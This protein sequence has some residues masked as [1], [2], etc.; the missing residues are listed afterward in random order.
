MLATKTDAASAVSSNSESP[1]KSQ[2][3]IDAGPGLRNVIAQSAEVREASRSQRLQRMLQALLDTTQANP[4]ATVAAF[5]QL[6]GSVLDA[7]MIATEAHMG[8]LQLIDANSQ[9][10]RIRV[11]RGFSPAFLQFFN[12][13]HS[14]AFACGTAFAQGGPVVVED[15]STSPLFE[16]DALRQMTAANIKGV[17]SLALVHEGTPLG[18]I[19]VHYHAG[20]VPARSRETFASTAT[21]IAA[22]VAAGAAGLTGA[23]RP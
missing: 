12:S 17:Q 11:H 22:I 6:L 1:F 13:V 5:D 4:P 3:S 21:L 7:V 23:H 15:V 20:G 9:S 16:G 18:V 19:S 2:V 8:N 10:L 14:G